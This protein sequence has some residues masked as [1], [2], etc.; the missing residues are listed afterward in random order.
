MSPSN[1]VY[2]VRHEQPQNDLLLRTSYS[3][4]P[5][6]PSSRQQQQRHFKIEKRRRR[7]RNAPSIVSSS[8]RN[9]LVV[10]AILAFMIAW[11]YFSTTSRTKP[12]VRNMRNIH[13][14]LYS[15]LVLLERLER[16]GGIPPAPPVRSGRPNFGNLQISFPSVRR[17]G[18]DGHVTVIADAEIRQIMHDPQQSIRKEARTK[19]ETENDDDSV[20]SYYAFDDDYLRNPYQLWDDDQIQDKR[21]C[22]RVSWHRFVVLSCTEQK[23]MA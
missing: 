9:V 23:V 20:Q 4:S 8:C 16:G 17:A 12:S 21:R 14:K 3:S 11:L 22:R 7:R 18:G 10:S 5:T 15:S 13:D 19:N 1:L 6:P 2:R